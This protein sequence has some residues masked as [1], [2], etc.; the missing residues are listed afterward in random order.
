MLF[1]NRRVGDEEA[2]LANFRPKGRRSGSEA[3]KL[4]TPDLLTSC[5]KLMTSCRTPNSCLTRV[6]ARAAAAA[7]GAGA[8][9]VGATAAGAS[10][11]AVRAGGHP[12]A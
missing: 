4:K 11:T 7:A 5:K 9:A 2:C 6:A 1:L 8:R 3:F 10:R 12:G